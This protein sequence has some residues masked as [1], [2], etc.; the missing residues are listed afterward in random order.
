M[1]LTPKE[2]I[3]YVLRDSLRIS[4]YQITMQMQW[5][6]SA[7]AVYAKLRLMFSAQLYAHMSF[8]LGQIVFIPELHLYQ[9]GE[10][11]TQWVNLMVEGVKSS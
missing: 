5:A 7:I 6:C 8:V 3:D 1:D 10:G 11:M 4:G 2:F 9:M